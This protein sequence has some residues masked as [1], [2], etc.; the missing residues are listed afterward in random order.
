MKFLKMLGNRRMHVPELAAV[1]FVKDNDHPF[2][3]DG[4]GGILFDKGG[5]LLNRG[6]DDLILMGIA[7]AV[8][9]LQLPL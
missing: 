9:V 5:Q 6:D 3:V 8:P 1:A 2:L 7:P 4:M